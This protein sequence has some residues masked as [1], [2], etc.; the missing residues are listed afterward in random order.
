MGTIFYKRNKVQLENFVETCILFLK[1]YREL[2]YEELKNIVLKI[3]AKDFNEYKKN[4]NKKFFRFLKKNIR[5][6]YYPQ[7]KFFKP[8]IKTSIDTRL[9]SINEIM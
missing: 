9:K 4:N 3:V 1:K 6:I 5:L 7:Q 8:K 2:S